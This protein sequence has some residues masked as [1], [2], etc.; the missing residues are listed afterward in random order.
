MTDKTDRQIWRIIPDMTAFFF[1]DKD[2]CFKICC[3]TM[4]EIDFKTIICFHIK[5]MPTHTLVDS[6]CNLKKRT[7]VVLVI[8][9]LLNSDLKVDFLNQSYK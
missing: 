5:N 6:A 2:Q 9:D 7:Q 1:K 3:L 4:D 8:S